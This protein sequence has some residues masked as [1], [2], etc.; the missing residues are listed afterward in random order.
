MTYPFD[1][2]YFLLFIQVLI[3]KYSFKKAC[4][5]NSQLSRSFKKFYRV[6]NERYGFGC[7]K[8]DIEYQILF[9][10]QNNIHCV[11]NDLGNV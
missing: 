11:F 1:K 2:K 10:L 5:L 7:E 9:Y 3:I 4:Y 6:I 8:G